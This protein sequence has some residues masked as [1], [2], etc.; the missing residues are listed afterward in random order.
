M[1]GKMENLKNSKI[2][3]LGRAWFSGKNTDTCVTRPTVG[4]KE[5]SSPWHP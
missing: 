2:S 3:S 4:L 5:M 1:K